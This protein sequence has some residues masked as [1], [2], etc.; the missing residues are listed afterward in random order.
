VGAAACAASAFAIGLTLGTVLG[1]RDR[2]EE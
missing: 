1:A 2:G